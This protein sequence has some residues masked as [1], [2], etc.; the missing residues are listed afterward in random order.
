[1]LGNT[2]TQSAYVILTTFPRQ[3]WFR[4]RFSFLLYRYIGCIDYSTVFLNMSTLKVHISTHRKYFPITNIDR[5]MSCNARELV[6]SENY[7][8]LVA[9]RS[10]AR[11]CGRSLAGIAGSNP[12]GVMAVCLL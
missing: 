6:N 5:L 1:M 2:H 9:E 10:K 11:V 4:E 3:A 8:I 12:A 7:V